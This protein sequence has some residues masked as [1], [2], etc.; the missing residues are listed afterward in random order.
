M[1]PWLGHAPDG[2]RSLG[3]AKFVHDNP[4][5]P[6]NLAPARR[7]NL[8]RPPG[9]AATSGSHPTIF[10]FIVGVAMPFSIARRR[11]QGQPFGR[12]L[13]HAILRSF[14][15]IALGVLLRSIGQHQT[16]YTFE[17]TLSQIGLGYTFA[18]LLGGFA[19]AGRSPPSPR[20][21]S[22]PR[23]LLGSPFALYPLPAANFDYSTVNVSPAFRASTR[24]MASPPTGTRT[25][26]PPPPS[27]SGSST[28]SPRLPV[29]RQ[30]RGYLTLSF[31]PTLATMLLGLLAGNLL[32]TAR[33]SPVSK[34]FILITAGLVGLG[35]GTLLDLTGVCPNVKP[36]DP[37]W[38]LFSAGWC[39]LL[40]AAST[41]SSTSRACA[42][43][44]SRWSS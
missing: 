7:A 36:S 40:L 5:A 32:R 43:G 23:R 28:S 20:P 12:L 31:I 26:T 13:F 1:L 21:S 25:P 35:L 6:A 14:I 3:F 38:T 33:M 9:A 18:F 4:A 2:L 37:T 24:C 10:T 30:R 41:S 15:L 44:P 17:D 27:T 22:Y 19:R 29:Q 42:R 39:C 16:Y 11:E 34:I 8:P